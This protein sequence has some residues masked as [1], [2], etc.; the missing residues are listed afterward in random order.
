MSKRIV[1]VIGTGAIGEPLIG[2]R[3]TTKSESSVFFP[4]C[5][6]KFNLSSS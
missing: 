6:M 4:T 1:H 5:S 3:R 2:L